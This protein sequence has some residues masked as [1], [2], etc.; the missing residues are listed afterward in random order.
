[1]AIGRLNT[2]VPWLQTVE[3]V[4]SYI[5]GAELGLKQAGERTSLLAKHQQMAQDRAKFPLEQRARNL[6]NSK[7][8]LDLAVV[9][10][11]RES[12]LAALDLGN[13]TTAQNLILDR[14]RAEDTHRTAELN[15]LKT[16]N[17]IDEMNREREDEFAAE[18]DQRL[19]NEYARDLGA[20]SRDPNA[21]D[22][23]MPK[24]PTFETQAVTKL[25]AEAE[26]GAWVEGQKRI[27]FTAQKERMAKDNNLLNE[28]GWDGDPATKV[29]V[30][31]E[32]N[33]VRA[34]ELA[35]TYHLG[36][37]QVVQALVPSGWVPD[38]NNYGYDTNG[39]YYL[40]HLTLPNGDLN[41][42]RVNAELE[43]AAQ[44]VLEEK[45]GG[46]KE[47]DI[48]R[49]AT[50]TTHQARLVPIEFLPTLDREAAEFRNDTTKKDAPELYPHP[51]PIKG[52]SDE[53]TYKKALS[54]WTANR[55]LWMRVAEDK[56]RYQNRTFPSQ[57]AAQAAAGKKGGK[58]LNSETWQV[59]TLAPT[60]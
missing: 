38:R 45:A 6:S 55:A 37:D 54:Y 47:V 46:M 49:Q 52:E 48:V 9:N 5:A 19:Y 1:M 56:I 36:G 39:N 22:I 3:P 43:A 4:Q 20:W 51:K 58:W 15:W 53:T 32:R 13:E 21:A 57:E 26:D 29:G 41:V 27:S 40:D 24:I 16:E 44:R 14:A 23:P 31:R 8:V 18:R 33:D 60:P 2:S 59:E 34:Q 10:E 35:N 17:E 12:R 25:A 7:A 42:R 28:F 50:P 30:Q 11:Q